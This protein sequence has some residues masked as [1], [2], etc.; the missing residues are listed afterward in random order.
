M[1]EIIACAAL[2]PASVQSR[3]QPVA[4]TTATAAHAMISRM[5]GCS[6]AI[7]RAGESY[8]MTFMMSLPETK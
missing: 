1:R 7:R 8:F 4:A 3:L 5:E 2:A 6:H